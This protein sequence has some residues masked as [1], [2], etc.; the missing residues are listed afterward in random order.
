MPQISLY[1]DK[2]TLSRIEKAAAKERLSI[3]KWVGKNIK[4]AIQDDY[5]QDYFSLFGSI[6]DKTFEI[7][8]ISFKDDSKRESL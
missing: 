6:T 3:S 7:K 1:V 2:D 4:K 5:P 8:K